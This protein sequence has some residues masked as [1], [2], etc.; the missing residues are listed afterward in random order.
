M[1]GIVLV[2][3]SRALALAAQELVRSMT[4]PA[5][6]LALAAGA[7]DDH[8]ELGTNAVEIAE[9]ITAVQ[10][11]AGVLVLMDMGSA[12][13]SAEMAL[14]LLDEPMRENVR[15]CPAPF[16]EGAVAAGVTA[17]LG[18]SLEEVFKEALAALKQKQAALTPGVTAEV[19]PVMEPSTGI[20]AQTV[21][22]KVTNTHGLHARPAARLISESRPFRSE[23][24]VR[25]LTNGRG[26]VS[27]KS[28]SSLASLEILQDHD[29]EI[30]AT[31]E[32]APA[33]L[34]ALAR[35]AREGFGEAL[36]PAGRVTA[37]RANEIPA[38]GPQA[39]AD[40][41]PVS[42]GIAL[43]TGVYFQ[44]AKPDVPRNK[45]ED[46]PAEID[47]LQ[48]AVAGV[49][50]S[51]EARHAQ[52]SAS[53]GAANAGIYE[54][55]ILSLQ[56]PE[57]IG[58]AI[59][60]IREEQANAALAW[61]RA[62]QQIVDR[63]RL[64]KDAYFRERAA[65]LEDVG[66]QVLEGLAGKQ[67]LTLV[68]TEPCILIA[69]DLTPTQV[70]G[71]A[72]DMVLGVILLDGGPTAHSSILLR[73]L[74]IPTVIQARAHLASLDSDRPESLAFDGSTGKIWL[75]S[76]E[77]L[78][79]ELRQR[80]DEEQKRGKEEL[81]A[82]IQPCTLSDGERIEMVA[83][84]GQAIEA[85][86]ALEMGAE[87]IGLLRTEFLFLERES[88]PTEEEQV[89]ALL[90]IA[91]IM[92]GRPITIRT[93]DAGGDKELPY[94]PMAT[95]SNPFLGVRAIRLCF[96]QESLFTTQLRAILRAGNGNDFQIM[97]PMVAT[98]ADLNRA[99]ACLERVHG[100]LEREQVPHLW[101]IP[102]G[103]MVEIPSAALQA[104]ALARQ[105]HFFSIGTN[106]L[107]Q[108]TLAADRGNP[109]L[110]SYQD[111]L[112]PSV[113]RLIEMTVKAARQQGRSVAV[114]GEAAS[115]EIA[116][117]IFIGLGVR[118]LSM[119]GAKIPRLKAAL[120]KRSLKE[121]QQQAASALLCPSATEVRALAR[122]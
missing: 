11:L 33:A 101:P 27:V 108:Y 83:N 122:S 17:N 85:G 78:L 50:L 36:P 62:N 117:G 2:S 30:A 116:A 66:W 57:L 100:D 110:A 40:P 105:A 14:D 69:D 49:Q 12:I 24:T 71:L 38:E 28:L 87:G 81:Q 82:G 120:R 7:G 52:M 25:N 55:Q 60:F 48:K 42:G 35:L 107:T 32:D 86:A 80:Q 75:Q 8:T 23:I 77:T 59:R 34:E 6:P 15:F 72:K 94:L 26:P 1:V 21:R 90:T 98:V 92:K 46:V 76:D 61:H 96:A 22:L 13:L 114:C 44:G 54:A 104:E 112:D 79:A 65:D 43:G 95:E 20:E 88:P 121:L 97:F 51:L 53:V 67:A 37:P 3:H 16:V 111:A 31:G 5:L 73:S 45:I 39:K 115:D 64:L 89:Q 74:G 119:S 93:L 99:L 18:A 19:A 103:I 102:T 118:E 9:A 56:D 113:L 91:E 41:V 10:S 47:R 109:A 58:E 84:I 106:D 68:L 29:I 63:Y 70:S 4:G